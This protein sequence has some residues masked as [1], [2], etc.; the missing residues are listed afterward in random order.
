MGYKEG[1]DWLAIAVLTVDERG[2]FE[3]EG[4]LEEYEVI[5]V[6]IDRSKFA[7]YAKS[8]V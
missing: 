8:N 5:E 4:W 2:M 6:A 1:E 3:V 7:Y